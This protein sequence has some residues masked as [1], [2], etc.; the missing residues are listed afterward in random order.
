[1]IQRNLLFLLFA[2]LTIV[3]CEDHKIAKELRNF[4]ETTITIPS[5]L[6]KISGRSQTELGEWSGKPTYV[7]YYD[8]LSCSTCRISHLVD[9]LELYEMS[10][11][12]GTFEVMTVFSPREYEYD[13]VVRQ[14]MIQDFP[15]PVYVDFS[16]NFRDENTFIPT[17]ERFHS[18]LIDSYGHPVLVGNPLAG[19]K[20][21]GLFLDVL[22]RLDASAE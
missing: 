2:S 4:R 6:H 18:F 14:L 9:Y 13:E 5:N 20:M 8:T 7:M 11:S 10:D 22:D 1:M 17:D 19:D 3:S 16:G 15:Y 21:M 12:L